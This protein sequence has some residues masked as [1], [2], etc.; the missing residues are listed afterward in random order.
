MNKHKSIDYKLSAVKF[1]INNHNKYSMNDISKIFDCPKQSLSRWVDRYNTYGN[2]D[3]KNKQQLSYKI[4]KEHVNFVLKLLKENKHY[5]LLELTKKVREKYDDF[6]VTPQHLG[7]VMRDNNITRKR[8]KLSHFPKKR[9]GKEINFNNELSK[10]YNVIDKYN[11]NNIISIDETSIQPYMVPEYCRS[12]LG[13]KCIDKTDDN[14]VFRKFTLLVAIS[15]KGLVGAKLYEKS[16][17]SKER[18]VDFIEE[19]IKGNY[20]HNLVVLD[21]AGSHNNNVV[22]NKIL[23]TGNEYLFT[24]PYTPKCN[25]I[26]SYFNQLKYFMKLNKPSSTFAEIKTNV[27]N[28]IK[29][30]KQKITKI[31][32]T[33]IT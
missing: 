10:F 1:Y 25:P 3:R 26:E 5:S 11:I 15:R 30:I 6:D 27:K 13:S 8:T 18:F 4:T 2:I 17:M 21:N 16:G 20:K 31:I 19:F 7:K 14:F 32:S 29:Q 23:E 33:I 12:K 28:A 22:K 9:F 24:V